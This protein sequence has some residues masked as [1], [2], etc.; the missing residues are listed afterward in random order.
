M[1]AASILRLS[2]TLLLVACTGAL[3][4]STSADACPADPPSLVADAGTHAIKTVFLIVMENKDWSS[5][6]GNPS[7]PYIN[8]TLLPQFAHATAY[9]NGGLHPSLPNYIELE[10]G[11]PLGVTRDVIPDAAPLPVTCHLSSWLTATGLSWKAY[12]EG[13]DG[14]ACPIYDGS[15]YAVRHDPAVYFEDVS[16]APPQPGSSRCIA[17]VRPF[18]ELATDLQAGTVPRWAFITPD[19]CHSGHDRCA[20]QHDEIRQEDDWLA[21]ELPRILAS[22]AWKDG[23]LVLITWDEG[24]AGDSPIGLL[25][26]SPLSKVGYAGAVPYSHASTLR[27]IQEALGVQPLLRRAADAQPLADLLTSYP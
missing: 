7:A 16:G 3:D 24:G 18:S 10:A 21:A 22:D 27:T 17:H 9:R 8:G 5:I 26:V 12:E 4:R 14:D 23:G 13:I 1:C 6:E 11:D 2:P 15:R 25:A 20:P 19:L